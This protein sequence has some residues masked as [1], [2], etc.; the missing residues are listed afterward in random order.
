[1]D[2]GWGYK[3]NFLSLILENPRIVN[4]LMEVCI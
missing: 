3:K 1:M 2:Q 4:V